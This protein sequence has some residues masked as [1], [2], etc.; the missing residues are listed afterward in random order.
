M[1]RTGCVPLCVLR[2]SVVNTA[3]CH[4]TQA[5]ISAFP[6]GDGNTLQLDLE[7]QEEPLRH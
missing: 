5:V 1:L 3:S 2:I 6:K 4:S 7:T